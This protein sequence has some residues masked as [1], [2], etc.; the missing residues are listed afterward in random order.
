[1]NWSRTISKSLL[2]I[3]GEFFHALQRGRQFAYDLGLLKSCKAPIKV[4]SVGNL[5]LGGSGKTPVVI[6]L[7]ERLGSIGLSPA[8]VSRGYGGSNRDPFLIVT[9]GM[10]EQ[11]REDSTVVG[12]E[13]FLIASRLRGVPVLVGRKRIHPVM[14]AVN[15]FGSN[16]VIL[17]D[18][19]QHLSLE[20]DLN[21]LVL[22]GN[23][24]EMLPL[25]E[26]RESMSAVQ[27]ADALMLPR[28]AIVPEAFKSLK[29]KPIFRLG[30][31]PV[32]LL[33]NKR[34]SE[35]VPPDTLRDRSVQLVSAIAR[36]E[37]FAHTARNLGWQVVAHVVHRDHHFFSDRELEHILNENPSMDIVFTEK[38]WVKLPDWFVNKDNTW[39][40][41]IDAEIDEEA[42]F[43]H[44]VMRWI[45]PRVSDGVNVC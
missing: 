13:P 42:D 31:K 34:F 4:I 21:L 36:P 16:V 33:F 6:W 19:F 25:I 24:H 5:V 39:A 28:H 7:A 20:R 44:F 18:G 22:V 41:R 2:T 23:E 1:M 38:D 17:D 15:L 32:G 27:R 14:A 26:L 29:N 9:D 40:L 12:D 30:Q 45:A 3:P 10:S 37:R 8:V 43:T 11:P 35:I